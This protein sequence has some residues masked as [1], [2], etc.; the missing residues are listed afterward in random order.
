MA[1]DKEND[2]ELLQTLETWI[3]NNFNIA[4]TARALY[5]H[6]NTVLYRMEKIS[7]ILNS[8]LKDA[9]ELLKYQLALKIYRLLDL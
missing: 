4:Q 7:T 8:D 1:Y 5:A 6:R 3:E 2:M 9:D